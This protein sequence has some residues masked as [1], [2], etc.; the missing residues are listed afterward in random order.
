[1]VR[2]VSDDRG[3]EV[4]GHF[5]YGR[6]L[7][8]RDGR[9]V[10]TDEANAPAQ[11]S[12]QTALSGDLYATLAAQSQGLTTLS[13]SYPNP[14]ASLANLAP[15]PDLQTA[16]IINDK[17]QPEFVDSAPNFVDTA[18]LGS[19]ERAKF[20]TSVEASQLSKALTLAE[21]TVKMDGATGSDT[22]GCILGRPDLAFLASGYQVQLTDTTAGT[23]PDA[24]TLFDQYSTFSTTDRAAGVAVIGGS[25]DLGRAQGGGSTTG[26]ARPVAPSLASSASSPEE[27]ASKINQILF[28]LYQVLDTPHQQWEEALRGANVPPDP[29]STEDIMFGQPT[30]QPVSPLSPPYSAPDRF[31]VG[32]PNAI[33]EMGQSNKAN[34][35]Q[36]WTDFS[37]NLKAAAK[38]KTP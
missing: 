31:A 19:P 25:E 28:D 5:R 13:T 27:M 4:I 2:P 18:P 6:G 33:A 23:T 37:K 36:S 24:S 20:P 29:R 26:G 11:I 15:D 30:D 14:A 32:D 12:V 8:L 7:Q 17:G 21:M 22:C 1:M 34:L 35:T 3:F 38:P 10:R 9:L 16:G